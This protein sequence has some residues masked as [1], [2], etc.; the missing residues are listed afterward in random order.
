MKLRIQD[1]SIRL[2][3]TR[4]EVT[5]LAQGEAITCQTDLAPQ[6]LV[7]KLGVA[8]NCPFPRVTFQRGH[9]DITVSISTVKKWASSD[10]VGIEAVLPSSSSDQSPV[11]LLIE[12]DFK[13]LHGSPEHQEDC[14]TNPLPEVPGM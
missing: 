8:A 5:V 9:L 2:R 1:N 4:S 13:C 14:F 7:Y 12:K 6:H 10:Q 3:L 11:Q